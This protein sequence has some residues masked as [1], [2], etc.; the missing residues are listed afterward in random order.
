M[1]EEKKPKK[2]KLFMA[3]L[4]SDEEAMERARRRL[5]FEYG[6]TDLESPSWTFDQTSYYEKEM[7][8]A[9]IKKLIAIHPLIDP[10]ELP[11]VK[12]NTNLLEKLFGRSDGT[13]LV[14]IDPGYL[15]L[16]KVVLATTKDYNHRLYLGNKIYG[17]V[18]L[19]YR[20]AEKSFMPWE[21]TYPDYRLPEVIGFFN[22]IRDIYREQIQQDLK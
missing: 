16:S 13:R 22:N 21:W 11:S 8:P 14:N 5:L 18:T 1:G 19:H 3:L 20:A 10:D 6:E 12:T 2:V 7:G 15:G 4:A 9:L 17:E